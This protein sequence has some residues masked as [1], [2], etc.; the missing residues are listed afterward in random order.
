MSFAEVLEIGRDTI[1]TTLLLGLPALAISLLVGLII[2][3]VQTITS[4]QDQT[5]SSVP[6][7]LAVAF[8]I[9]F[10]MGWALQTAIQFFVRMLGHAVEVTR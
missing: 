9:V 3:V 10:T 1:W 8:A 6:R 5:L 7:I 2:S 4:I